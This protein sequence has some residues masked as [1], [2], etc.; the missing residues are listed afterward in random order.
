MATWIGNLR[1]VCSTLPTVMIALIA[2]L[3]GSQASAQQ[4]ALHQVD[5]SDWD[6]LLRKYV[7][8][9]GMVDY[10]RWKQSPEDRSRLRRYLRHLGRANPALRT[11]R[12]AKLAF[13]INAYNALT[14]SGILHFYPTSSIRN[15]TARFFGYNIWEDLLLPVGGR[16]YSLDDIEHKILRRMG[17]PRI[18]FA[19]VCASKGCPRLRNEAYVPEL[20]DKQLDDNARDFF[21]RPKHFQVDYARKL[22]RVSSILKWFQEDFG[23]TPQQALAR[24]ARYL[25]DERARGLVL[26]GN[27]SVSYLPYDWSLNEQ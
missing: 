11:T 14:I 16:K 10:A 4:I 9:D 17:D 21:R 1:A 20:V 8:E 2:L 18:H 7:D 26:S 24:V 19:I 23:P 5:H 3:L 13:W 6:L 15:H 22:V 12:Q 27:F 25:P